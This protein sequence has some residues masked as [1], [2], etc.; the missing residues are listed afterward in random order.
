MRASRNTLAEG[1]ADSTN[2]TVENV[3]DDGTE[4]ACEWPVVPTKIILKEQIWA[5]LQVRL[6]PTQ[7]NQNKRCICYVPI[8][9]LIVNQIL[10]S[11]Y[12]YYI[13]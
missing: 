8:A 1:G 5:F 2:S 12:W 6:A 10:I 3:V 13:S 4:G 7:A 11:L 9:N